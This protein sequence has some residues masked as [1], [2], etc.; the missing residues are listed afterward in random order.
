MKT[1]GNIACRGRSTRTLPRFQWLLL[2]AAGVLFINPGCEKRFDEY[3][4]VPDDLIGT[5]LDVLEEEGNYTQFIRAVELVDFADV[6]GR[7]GNF[8][9]FAP[10]DAAFAGFFNESGYTSLE[11]IPEEE[12]KGIV[13]YHIVFWAYSKF[14]LMYG[15]NIQDEDIEYSAENFKQP[16]RYTPPRTIEFDTLGR[17]FTVHHETKYIPVYTTEFFDEMDL[18]GISDYN[19]LYPGS[20]FSGFHV[21][22]A[23]ITDFDV[24]A[25]NGWIHRIDRVLIPPPNHDDI[26]E[27]HSQYSMFRKLL[28]RNTFYQYSSSYTTSQDNEGDVNEDGILDSLF[29]KMNSIFPADASPDVENVAGAGFQNVLTLFAP[30][31]NALEQFLLTH[32]S[33]YG[34]MESI[35]DWW[36]D[37]YLSHYVGLNYW[38]SGFSGLTEEWEWDLTTTLVDCDVAEG[39][40][41]MLQMAS[42]GPFCGINKYFLPRIFESVAQPIMGNSEYEW[43]QDMLVFYLVE[44][45]LTEENLEFTIFA[46]TNAAI[47]AAGYSF[48]DGLGGYGLYHSSNP[49]DPVSHRV[50]KDIVSTHLLF[51]EFYPDDFEEGTFIETSQNTY[52]GVDPNGIFAGGD[53]IP[54][55]MEGPE[56]VSGKGLL[57]RVDRMMVS[58][59]H[60]IFEIIS[61]TGTNPQYRE[62]YKLCYESG[63]IVLD[64]EQAP[65][66]LGNISTGTYYS[67]F[68]PT[69]QAILDGRADGSIPADPD[70]LQQ[71]L[72]YHFVEGVVFDDGKKSGTFNTTRIDEVSGY[73]FNTIEISNQKYDLEIMDN[74]GNTRSVITANRMAEDGVIHQIDNCLIFNSMK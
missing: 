21:D 50:A 11:E 36:L 55:H 1:S 20:D 30:T 14:M 53:L 72:R 40:I 44:K 34:S 70:S 6:L 22:R 8:T 68:I 3:Y 42:N 12:L 46:P 5:I 56:E 13:F 18:D 2:L 57:Y 49:L 25:Q 38:P 66:S 62:F 60:S 71:F 51:G 32:T 16:T 9:V 35:G 41:E 27:Q 63:L 4:R 43:F 61:T 17:R 23:T 67:C 47:R 73:L 69:N 24:P 10:D 15:L 74:M 31:D 29:L 7:T 59:Y 54:S 48:R 52:I 26:L 45:L 65:Q 58:P 37:W 28:E 39:D 19:L 33:G 64:E